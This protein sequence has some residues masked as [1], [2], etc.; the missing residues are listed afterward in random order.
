[1]RHIAIITTSFPEGE[2]GR[3]SAGSFVE[4][5]A[6]ALAEY[7][8][9]T[10]VAPSRKKMTVE[11]HGNLT[12]RRFSVPRQ[13]LSILTPY[14]PAH[15][16]SI[17]QTLLA[18]WHAVERLVNEEKVDHIFSLWVLPSGFWARKAWKRYG[19]PYSTWALGSDIWSLRRVPVVKGILATVLRNSHTCFADGYELKK[20]VEVIS[21]RSCEFLAS[22]RN[23]PV[24]EKKRLSSVPPYKLA[25]LGRWHHNKGVDLMFNSLGLLG[26]EDWDKIE[27]VRIHG[28]GPLERTLRSAVAALER[29][30]RPVSVGGYLGKEEAAELLAW[31]DYLLLPSRLESIPVVFSDAM[32]AGCPVIAMP[33]GDLPRL[34]GDNEVGIL[35]DE[36]TAEAFA[37]A[38]RAALAI[39]P[40]R[41]SP[42][43]KEACKMFDV[44]RTA[45]RLLDLILTSENHACISPN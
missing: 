27:E 6:E 22:S 18:G 24:V 2:S 10:V 43:L 33:A 15:W 11:R 25:F 39:P 3:E 41:F 35:A 31:A 20:D 8:N 17:Y 23:L 29:A 26:D 19:I 9:V 44:N 14:N 37:R 32:Q 13:P 12:I 40:E 34:M 5:F 1:M 30:G 7:I 21:G 16:I 42:G 4:D 28:G 45:S 38:M 36:V